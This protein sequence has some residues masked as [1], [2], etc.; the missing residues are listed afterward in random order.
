MCHA[1]WH[2]KKVILIHQVLFHL[3][4]GIYVFPNFGGRLGCWK[5]FGRNSIAFLLILIAPTERFRVCDH[6]RKLSSSITISQRFTFK[7]RSVQIKHADCRK[8]DLIASRPF[9][10]AIKLLHFHSS[11]NF[12]TGFHLRSWL[13]LSDGGKSTL[14][15]GLPPHSPH[16]CSC[17]QPSSSLLSCF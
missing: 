11:L 2:V 4:L 9:S 17:R 15:C 6:L 5:A 14:Q 10:N 13:A 1:S 12:M 3:H 8:G 16:P 7:T